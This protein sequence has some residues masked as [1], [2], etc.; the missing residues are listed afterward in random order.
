MELLMLAVGWVLAGFV[1]LTGLLVLWLMF[2]GRIQLDKLISEPDGDASLSR[3]QF[4]IFTF[5]IAMSVFVITVSRTPPQFPE[6]PTSVLALMGISAGSYVLA[7]G[8]QTSR[9]TR[10]KEIAAE[11]EQRKT[12]VTLTTTVPGPATNGS[13]VAAAGPGAPTVTPLG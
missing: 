9:D 7:K 12:E 2:R 10:T 6:I 11:S 3:F 13:A 4:L 8:I 1:G 5:V